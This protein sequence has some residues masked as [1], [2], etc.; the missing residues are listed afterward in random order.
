MTNWTWG[1]KEHECQA[2]DGSISTLA[3]NFTKLEQ[4]MIK[5]IMIF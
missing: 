5:I 1:K 3:D 2:D 4:I